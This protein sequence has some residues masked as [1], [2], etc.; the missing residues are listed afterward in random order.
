MGPLNRVILTQYCLFLMYHLVLVLT[1]LFNLYSNIW[2]VE[3]SPNLDV[4]LVL[5]DQVVVQGEKETKGKE[6]AETGNNVEGDT[7]RAF[8]VP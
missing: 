3:R 2:S 7:F 1:Q 6:E 4:G 8:C 5:L